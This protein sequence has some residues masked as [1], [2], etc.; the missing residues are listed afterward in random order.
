MGKC[1]KSKVNFNTEA[2]EKIVYEPQ[3]VLDNQEEFWTG[4]PVQQYARDWAEQVKY[5]IDYDEWRQR[6]S[7]WAAMPLK[8]RESSIFLRNTERIL[9][10][11]GIFLE[12]ALPYLC[13]YLPSDANLDI[14]I[15]F[16]AF[17]P[18]RAFAMGEIGINVAANYWKNNA[19]NILN[20]LV[21]ELFHVGFS[22][23]EEQ[24]GIEYDQDD[25]IL[26]IL[27]NIHNEGIC[28]YV[29]YNAQDIFPAP[30]E[31]DFQYLDDPQLVDHHIS[32]VNMILEKVGKIPG[33]EL[34][35]LS[36]DVGVIGR[37]FYVTGA[38]MCKVIEENAGR[39]SL[40]NTMTEGPESFLR[41]YHKYADA[42]RKLNA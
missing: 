34:D 16:T 21:H 27:R 20:V 42:S 28:T 25:A 22:Y 17:I 41:L 35:K 33:E 10:G 36:W 23:C 40:V 5:T 29:A 3:W 1:L 37:S 15:H 13:S 12:K 24:S 30:D 2:L 19:D 11:K 39:Q 26:G 9:E 32:N 8:E 6:I 7:D 31:K 4:Y 14:G 18:P 38:L